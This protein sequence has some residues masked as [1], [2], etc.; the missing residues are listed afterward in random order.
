MIFTDSAAPTGFTKSTAHNNKSLR[1]VSGTGGGSGGTTGFTTAFTSYPA[2][3]FS[4][5][6]ANHTLTTPQLPAHTHDLVIAVG[7]SVL[8][9]DG[10]GFN[11]SGTLGNTGGGESHNHAVTGSGPLNIAVRYIDAIIATRDA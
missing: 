7:P 1:V 11:A 8:V 2:I 4:G 6:T 3:S 9:I 5:N 10:T